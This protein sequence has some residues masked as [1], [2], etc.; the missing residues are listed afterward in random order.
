MTNEICPNES[1]ELN[2]YKIIS[3]YFKS[4]DDDDAYSLLFLPTPESFEIIC[5]SHLV[6]DVINFN[7][8]KYESFFSKIGEENPDDA[9]FA[10]NLDKIDYIINKDILVFILI[11]LGA[12]NSI[13]TIYDILDDDEVDMPLNDAYFDNSSNYLQ[14]IYSIIDFLRKNEKFYIPYGQMSLFF[15]SLDELG[16]H[17]E[18]DD[19]N[20][21]YR[22]VKDSF[23]LMEKNKILILVAPSNNFWIKSAKSN[24][25]DQYYDIKLNNY[26]NI[27]YNKK[28]IKKFMSKVT[29]HP[30]CNFG[31]ISS[32]THRNLK[33]CWEALEKQFSQDCPKKIILIDQK[34]HEQVMLDPNMK[35]MSFFRSMK[36]IMELLK[37]EKAK[38]LKTPLKKNE[39]D[40]D[41]I[42]TTIEEGDNIEC[43]SEK[44]IIILES[45]ENKM[46][47]DTK[48]N[49]F[50]M[51]VFNEKYLESTVKQREA[52]DLEGD[53]AINFIMNLLENCTDDIREYLNRH[54]N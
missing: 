46:S 53:E 15:K 3:K 21:L 10:F 9:K 47:P 51:N 42:D 35:K 23:F 32:M 30:R 38:E 50:M 5:K 48:C 17:I 31:L 18:P 34:D 22:T 36:K 12:I 49:S 54:K 43:F 4:K 44:N 29:K 52:N 11:F 1:V 25:N 19:K 14:Y 40:E 27:Y 45:E 39:K 24:I 20:V 33:N 26:N 37:K 28:F 2:E 16:F 7:R 6:K 8:K 41:S 13:N